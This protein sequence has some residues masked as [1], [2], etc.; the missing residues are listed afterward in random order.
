MTDVAL[1]AD[2]LSKCFRLTRDRRFTVK[3]RF[4]RGRAKGYQEFWALRDVTFEV[5]KGSFFGIV[6]HNGSGKSTALKVLAGIYRP[7]SG[8]V[9]VNGR[10]RALL[11][12]G[13]GFHPELTGR[14]NIQLNASILG[15]TQREIRMHMDEIIEFAGIGEFIDSPVKVYSSGM[16]VRLGFAVAVKMDPEILIVD[17]VIAVGDEEFQRRCQE[18]M[19]QLRRQGKT[20]VLVTHAM[21]VVQDLCD[22]ALWLDHG[23]VKTLGTANDVV[24]QYMQ[25][26]NTVEAS[27][28]AVLPGALGA[29]DPDRRGSGEIRVS[30]V[31]V[32]H[33][34][35]EPVTVVTSNMACRFRIRLSASEPVA[36]FHVSLGFYTETGVCVSFVET[37]RSGKQQSV[38]AGDGYIDFDMS[39][40]PLQPGTY[41]LSVVVSREGHFYDLLDQDVVLLVRSSQQSLGLVDFNGNWGDVV[42]GEPTAGSAAISEF[43]S[44]D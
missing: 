10:L 3:E 16:A 25:Q 32:L 35:G 21:G 33:L 5:K 40:L 37:R 39:A 44:Q 15:M 6:G 27:R 17:E 43:H 4:V 24:R 23:T 11:E 34:D 42:T 28:S 12:L 38:A 7:S 19:F 29:L 14:E 13:A 36:D 2:H 18:Y 31:E 20:I 30:G 22:E 8:A 1:S 9:T 41:L 26:V